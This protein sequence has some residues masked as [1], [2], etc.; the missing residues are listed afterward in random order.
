MQTV[1]AVLAAGR[2][3]GKADGE[4]AD[5]WPLLAAPDLLRCHA[6]LADA[7]HRDAA[8]LSDEL[9]RRLQDH[10]AQLPDEVARARLCALPHW[11][12]TLR[13]TGA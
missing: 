1:L 10:L 6:I 12:A 5:R 9:K 7:C 2:G 11:Q 4:V 3:D 8:R 13:L